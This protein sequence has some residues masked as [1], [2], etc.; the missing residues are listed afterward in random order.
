MSA[1]VTRAFRVL[2][3]LSAAP[4][5]TGVDALSAELGVPTSTV[6][7]LLVELEELGYVRARDD[8]L[9]VAGLRLVSQALR[10]LAHIPLI[11]MAK[12]ALDRLA[13]KSGELARLSIPDQDS[14]V[15]V[16]KSQGARGGLRYDPDAGREVKL[17][18]TSSGLAW[19]STMSDDDA[20]SLLSAQ[21]F[22][23]MGRF[24]PDGPSDL[25]S[26]L[27]LVHA[28]RA[29]GYAYT[30]STY[31]LGISVVA[32]PVAHPGQS[33]VAVLSIAGPSVRLTEVLVAQLIPELARAR[34]ELM[35][36]A[37]SMLHA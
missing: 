14:L 2:D 11:D 32:M 28:V 20:A 4:D 15:W 25:E 8:E 1:A 36:L 18:R 37:D 23:D 16:A 31:E 12:P 3:L 30:A 10:H 17:A 29:R 26:A 22:D 33:A 21:G 5:G 19:L 27:K 7:R 24:G 34:D 9:Y 6:R 13:A 35:I